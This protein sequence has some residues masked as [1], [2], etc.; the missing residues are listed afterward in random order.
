MTSETTFAC[1]GLAAAD[2]HVQPSRFIRT[3]VAMSAALVKAGRGAFDMWDESDDLPSLAMIIP[4]GVL[5]IY[6]IWAV[7]S[8]L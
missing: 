6:T 7:I 1:S 8:S 5:S 2:R 3:P 4:L